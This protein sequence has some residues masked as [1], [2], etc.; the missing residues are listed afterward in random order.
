MS[1]RQTKPE[2]RQPSKEELEEVIQID[3]TPDEIAAAVLAGGAPRRGN[4]PTDA[5]AWAVGLTRMLDSSP[6]DLGAPPAPPFTLSSSAGG[7]PTCFAGRTEPSRPVRQERGRWQSRSS[8]R[9]RIFFPNEWRVWIKRARSFARRS[10]RPAQTSVG[11]AGQRPGGA[12]IIHGFGQTLSFTVAM[13]GP[14]GSD[15]SSAGLSPREQR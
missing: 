9:P 3:A 15:D 1:D 10:R 4:P 6:A 12:P 7:A 5:A 14:A 2:T 8:G 13:E 11:T